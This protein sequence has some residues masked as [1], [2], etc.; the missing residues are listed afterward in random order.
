MMKAICILMTVLI[1]VGM[2][3]EL[4]NPRDRLLETVEATGFVSQGFKDGKKIYFIEGERVKK[5]GHAAMFEGVKLT[6]FTESGVFV[7]TTP[8]CTLNY[9]KNTI[10]GIDPR[11]EGD[12]ARMSGSDFTF[13]I[14]EQKLLV[15]NVLF[16]VDGSVDVARQ[17]TIRT[18]DDE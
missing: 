1:T 16:I 3:G 5:I 17:M 15:E 10:C 6:L 7:V 14:K 2:A 4:R 9:L 11:I 8:A 13:F 18:G 12:K